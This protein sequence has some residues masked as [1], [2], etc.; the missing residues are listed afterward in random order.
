MIVI[1]V[2]ANTP[3][4]LVIAWAVNNTRSGSQIVTNIVD[5]VR[6]YHKTVEFADEVDAQHFKEVWWFLGR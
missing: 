6:L 4:E 1:P 3:N 2:V 5:G